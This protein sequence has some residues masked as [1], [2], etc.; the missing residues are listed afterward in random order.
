MIKYLATIS[1]LKPKGNH[2]KSPLTNS[3]SLSRFGSTLKG[4]GFI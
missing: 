1:N 2:E 3:L 4:T